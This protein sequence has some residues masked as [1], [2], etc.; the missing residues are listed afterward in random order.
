M[1]WIRILT[2]VKI[3]TIYKWL[4]QSL[5]ELILDNPD[6]P[7]IG[8]CQMNKMW[9]GKIA[10]HKAVFIYSWQLNKKGWKEKEA[11]TNVNTMGLWKE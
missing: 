3:N 8:W 11:L 9:H 5:A 7:I 2:E 10:R 4:I 6:V 1:R